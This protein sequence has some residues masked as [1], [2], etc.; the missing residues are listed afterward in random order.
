MLCSLALCGTAAITHRWMAMQRAKVRPAELYEI[1]WKQIDA[2]READYSRAYRHASARFQERFN[3]DAFAELVRSD[4]PDLVRADR[5][6]FGTVRIV[7][8]HALVQVFF[9]LPDGDV[10]PCVYSLVNEGDGWKIDAA[11][12]QKRWPTGR[13]LGGVRA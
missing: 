13:R 5:V 1:V 4:Y 8:R 10:V 9:F 3:V 7:D 6:E 2:F 11:R 12:F